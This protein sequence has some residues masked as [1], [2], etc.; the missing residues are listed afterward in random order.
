V[1]V[2][3]APLIVIGLI[4]TEE[5]PTETTR[6]APRRRARTCEYDGSPC[7]IGLPGFFQWGTLESCI[8][9]IAAKPYDGKHEGNTFAHPHTPYAQA[10]D[11]N[12]AL[13]WRRAMLT[14]SSPLPSV[15][16]TVRGA[17]AML[18]TYLIPSLLGDDNLYWNRTFDVVLKRGP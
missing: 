10:A 5:D 8:P 11:G 7:S 2:Y 12:S 18:L 16:D 6:Y 13:H 9:K 1:H 14:L 4:T 15:R 3:K 17:W